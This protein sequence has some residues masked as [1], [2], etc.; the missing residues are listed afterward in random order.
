MDY[1]NPFPTAPRPTQAQAAAVRMLREA[2]AAVPGE[3]AVRV[4][5]SVL[6]D[7]LQ[8][9]QLEELSNLLGRAGHEK[10]RPNG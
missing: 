6:A 10:A 7:Q 9:S 5:Y 4:V 3:T 2:L 8:P 1:L